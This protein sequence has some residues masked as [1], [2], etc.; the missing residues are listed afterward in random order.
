VRH[1]ISAIRAWRPD[2]DH[3]LASVRISLEDRQVVIG[4]DGLFIE[5]ASGQILLSMPPQS[6]DPVDEV[7]D[8][9]KTGGSDEVESVDDVMAKA[10]A[11]DERGDDEAAERHYR[12]CLTMDPTCGWALINLGNL[13]FRRGEKQ[14][15][16]SLYE[17]AT[18]AMPDE[19]AP[20]YNLANALDDLERTDQ[21]AHAYREALSRDPDY[22][23]AHFNLGLL[24]EKLGQRGR[25]RH[26]WEA[27]L[28]LAPNH[29]SAETAAAFLEP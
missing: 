21:A 25:A 27:F 2:I 16:C 12:R 4:L 15:A 1:A 17:V 6:M 10:L 22:A 28:H 11:A 9:P 29:P 7:I 24:L 14:T 18:R 26:H 3:P 8:Y 13:L 5:P 19:P 20:W 23:D